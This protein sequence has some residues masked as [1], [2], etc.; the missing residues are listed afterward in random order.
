MRYLKVF[1]EFLT[2]SKVIDLALD[3]IDGLPK[4]SIFDDAKNI[5]GIFKRSKHSWSEVIETFEKNQTSA[6]LK[7]VNV[8]DIQ[9]TQPNIQINKVKKMLHDFNK[10]EPIN[11]VEFSDGLAIYDGHHRLLTAWAL[12]KT[13]LKVNYIKA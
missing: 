11:V 7:S 3:R 13:K 1:E 10:L 5:D 6:K 9:I 2:E 8:K 4:G 12:G